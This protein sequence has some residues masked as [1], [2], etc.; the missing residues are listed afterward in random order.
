[1]T[2]S[3]FLQGSAA[4]TLTALGMAL[5]L[6]GCAPALRQAPTDAAVTVPSTWAQTEAAATSGPQAAVPTAWWQA[7]GDEKLNGYVQAALAR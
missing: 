2:R 5:L 6:A 4:T 1:M 3:R 7:F